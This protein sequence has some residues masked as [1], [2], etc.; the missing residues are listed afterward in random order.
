MRTTLAIDDDV[1]SAVKGLANV[2]RQSVGTILSSLA[3]Q[4][5]A[6]SQP[7]LRVRN[8][9]PLLAG[10]GAGKAI[11]SELVNQLRDELQ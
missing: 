8:G 1:F 10:H 4:A 5:L 6:A 11:T 3:R 9:V 2:Q 7:P